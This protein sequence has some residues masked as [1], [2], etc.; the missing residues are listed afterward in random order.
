MFHSRFF[1]RAGAR[2][3]RDKKEISTETFY[4][5]Q[6]RER[7]SPNPADSMNPDRIIHLA[8]SRRSR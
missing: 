2:Y 3:I 4:S 8:D 6:E 7:G 1:S 5:C